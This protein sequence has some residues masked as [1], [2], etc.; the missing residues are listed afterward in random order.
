MDA[1]GLQ[2]SAGQVLQDG[3]ARTT[4]KIITG[5]IEMAALGRI[6]QRMTIN[7]QCVVYVVQDHVKENPDFFESTC[8][9]LQLTPTNY[10]S[11]ILQVMKSIFD[12]KEINWG[13]IIALLSFCQSAC[14]HSQKIGLPLSAIDSMVPWATMF[15]CTHLKEWIMLQG[16]WVSVCVCVCRICIIL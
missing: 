15:I 16:G 3:F 5:C 1:D 12:D 8:E 10:N 6:A 11:K 9:E 13:R 14:V 4:Q 7:E 2:K